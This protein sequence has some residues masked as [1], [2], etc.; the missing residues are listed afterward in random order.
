MENTIKEMELKMKK[1][2]D[3]F[4]KDL[5]TIGTGVQQRSNSMFPATPQAPVNKVIPGFRQHIG[6]NVIWEIA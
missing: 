1:S 5:T 4:Q 3:A 2:I 6:L